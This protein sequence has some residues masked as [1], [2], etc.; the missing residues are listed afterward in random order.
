MRC[1]NGL[2]YRENHEA[3][4]WLCAPD[5]KHIVGMCR[6]DADIVIQE[7]QEKLGKRWYFREIEEKA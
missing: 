2:G 6:A 4:G 3:E 1:T 5:G 7:Y